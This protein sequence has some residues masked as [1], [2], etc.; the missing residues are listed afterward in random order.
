MSFRPF[1]LLTALSMLATPL[2]AATTKPRVAPKPSTASAPATSAAKGATASPAPAASSAAAP[3][4]I[5]G[6][7]NLKSIHPMPVG[8]RHLPGQVIIGQILSL[9]A[10]ATK[11]HVKNLRGEE[12]DLVI[13][14]K[15]EMQSKEPLAVGKTIRTR[16]EQVDGQNVPFFIRVLESPDDVW[17]KKHAQPATASPAPASAASPAGKN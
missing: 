13:T 3:A 5:S 8:I 14:P 1:L 11:L 9:D 2:G 12:F 10:T 16:F 4:S 7:S 15:T 17:Q 6:P